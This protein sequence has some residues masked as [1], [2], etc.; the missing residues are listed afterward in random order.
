MNRFLRFNIDKIRSIIRG[1]LPKYPSTMYS[2]G[3]SYI[4]LLTVIHPFAMYTNISKDMYGGIVDCIHSLISQLTGGDVTD[5]TTLSNLSQY[6]RYFDTKRSKTSS[7]FANAAAHIAPS[8]KSSMTHSKS[9]SFGN[10][11]S[12]CH[13]HPKNLPKRRFKSRLSSFAQ[14]IGFRSKNSTTIETKTILPQR[15]RFSLLRTPIYVRNGVRSLVGKAYT[16][17]NGIYRNMRSKA[18][19]SRENNV[20]RVKIASEYI[21]N[22]TRFTC[23]CDDVD[24]LTDETNITPYGNLN[25]DIAL[26][27]TYMSKDEK[28]WK[29]INEENDIRVWKTHSALCDDPKDKKWVCVMAKTRIEAPAS[30]LLSLL[31]DSD[32]VTL[33]NRYVLMP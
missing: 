14:R 32:K 6:D 4:V 21:F 28:F 27:F 31:F 26:A 13:D 30:K 5:W 3:I 10:D 18:R 29:Y 22:A 7:L 24:G 1:N 17:F 9:S 25:E 16:R 2:L 19:K 12:T 23:A 11:S 8:V 20:N 15:K 33:L